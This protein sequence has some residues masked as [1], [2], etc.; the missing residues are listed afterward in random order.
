MPRA[1]EP[2]GDLTPK[3]LPKQAAT[4]RCHALVMML[5]PDEAPVAA[6][7]ALDR[8]TACLVENGDLHSDTSSNTRG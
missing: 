6:D 5:G 4:Q 2:R 8:R 3:R 1:S 7:W